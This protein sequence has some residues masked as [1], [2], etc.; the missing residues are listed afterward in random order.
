MAYSRVPNNRRLDIVIIINN[1]GGWNNR[2]VGGSLKKS[3]DGFL[4]LIIKQIFPIPFN[5]RKLGR[6]SFPVSEGTEKIAG[7]WFAREDQYPGWCYGYK[8]KGNMKIDMYIQGK[9]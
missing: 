7:L 6:L 9:L 2:G 8:V 1:R 4:V 3:V 5:T